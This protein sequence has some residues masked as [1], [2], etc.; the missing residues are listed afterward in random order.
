MFLADFPYSSN[1]F[2]ESKTKRFVIKHIFDY[3]R[4]KGTPR[5]AQLLL[6][7]LFNE[8]AK[9]Y[10]PAKDVLKVSDSKWVIPTYLEVNYSPRT[11][12][13][14]NKQIT[15]VSSGAKAFVESIVTKR[16]LGR[17]IDVLYLS[18]VRGNFQNSE[19]ITDDGSFKDA[20]KIIGSL[21]S[22]V[23]ENGGRNTKIGD[24]FNVIDTSGKHGVA[25]VTGTVDA[26][27]RVNFDIENGGSGYTLTDR[28]EV[29]VATA[30]LKVDN[31]D[32]ESNDY[33]LYENVEQPREIVSVVSATDVL[34]NV[35]EVGDYIRGVRTYVE[36]T[37][38]TT[39]QLVFPRHTQSTI[40]VIVTKDPEA[41][42]GDVLVDSS[43]YTVNPNDVTFTV[44]PVTAGGVIKVVNYVETANGIVISMAN[45]ILGETV[46]Q[47]TTD[48]NV[49][50]VV[51]G[52]DR[53][54]FNTQSQLDFTSAV[55]YIEEEII[56]E[57]QVVQLTVTNVVGT[58][59]VGETVEQFVYAGTSPNEY[60]ENYAFGKFVSLNN[61]IVELEESWGEFQQ[62]VLI[63][64]KDSQASAVMS[65]QTITEIGSKGKVTEVLDSD[66]VIVQDII[67]GSGAAFDVGKKVYGFTSH[68][69]GEVAVNTPIGSNSIWYNGDPSANGVVDSVANNTPTGIVVGSNST[70]VGLWGNTLPFSSL[71]HLVEEGVNTD[72][73]IVTTRERIR[74]HNLINQPNKYKE[75]LQVA[76]GNGATFEPGSL[77]NEEIIS[78]NTDLLGARN[79]GNVLFMDIVA[80]TAANSGV[81]FITSIDV[82]NGGSGYTDLD[83]VTFSGGGYGGAEPLLHAQAH[84]LVTA[85]VIT[86][87]EVDFPGEGYY[88]A[89]TITL[90]VSGNGAAATINMGFGYGFP[91][92]PTSDGNTPIA[93]MLDIENMTI[94]T[95]T[96]LRRINPGANYNTDPFV[97]VLNK[98]V[99]GF[100]RKDILLLIDLGAGAFK[101]GESVY[102]NSIRK[103]VVKEST[104]DYI[105]LERTSFNES[106]T[107]DPISGDESNAAASVLNVL[108]VE[109]SLGMGENAVIPGEVIVANGVAVS[110]EIKD[111][112]YGYYNNKTVSL[113][114]VDSDNPFVMTATSKTERQGIGSGYWITESS[115]L[116]SPKKIH[117]NDYYQEY[118]YDIQTGISLD[119]YRSIVEKVLHVS[120][121]KLFGTVVRVSDINTSVKVASSTTETVTVG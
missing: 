99:A 94:G 118:S 98:Y 55:P 113:E 44:A 3:Y 28:T 75:V 32:I 108:T 23:I 8:E 42:G 73:Q 68:I 86:G 84:I 65:V 91:K 64:G 5:S 78:V 4:S 49:T 107:Y 31:S 72:I 106:F 109:D 50:L 2:S 79:T 45:T 112:G 57:E 119:R 120:G 37:T 60:L 66:S 89:P 62:D 48:G 58:F 40:D 46:S 80:G 104:V 47:A 51:A 67:L 16:I 101:V 96:S 121:T 105:V 24:L 76:T 13:F 22:L 10:Y 95:I 69:I 93:D 21:S 20:P 38:A 39:N 56:Q 41:D 54:T 63:T 114:S 25:R 97:S 36:S 1:G 110:V 87:I 70:W 19:I 6:R 74:E 26:T 11:K 7:M 83:S 102:Q 71:S 117:D 29:K 14:F 77:E 90:P 88:S 12:G 115:H 15:G 9:V 85:G 92:S 52:A 33:L 82:D 116:N 43:E 27:G 81:G 18:H 17:Y 34:A 103:G 30:M 111:S 53:G 35:W 100:K 59:Q 61:S